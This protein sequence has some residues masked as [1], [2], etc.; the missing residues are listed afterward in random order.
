MPSTAALIVLALAGLAWLI[1][2]GIR[3]RTQPLWGEGAG[4]FALRLVVGLGIFGAIAL[5]VTW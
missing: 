5:L 3:F 4:L 1:A 2:T